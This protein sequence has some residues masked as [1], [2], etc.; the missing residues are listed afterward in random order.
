MVSVCVYISWIQL[1]CV[2]KDILDKDGRPG[3]GQSASRD[4][5]FS[6]RG[7]MIRGMDRRNWD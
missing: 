2:S 3:D 4:P 7:G 1:V 5:T 6:D